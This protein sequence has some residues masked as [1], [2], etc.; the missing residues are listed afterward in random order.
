LLILLD[1]IVRTYCERGFFFVGDDVVHMSLVKCLRAEAG[2][3]C[4]RLWK[5]PAGRQWAGAEG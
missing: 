4:S 3:R 1:L 5:S 2:A